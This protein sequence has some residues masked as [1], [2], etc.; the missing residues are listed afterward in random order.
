MLRR[1]VSAAWLDV[2]TYEQVENDPNA[3][4]QAVLVVIIVALAAGIGGLLALGDEAVNPIWAWCL[5]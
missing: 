2:T 1:M 4:I 3:T 5:A